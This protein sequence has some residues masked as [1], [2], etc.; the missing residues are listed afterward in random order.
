[1]Y[2]RQQLDKMSTCKVLKLAFIID[3]KTD[4][5]AVIVPV[6]NYC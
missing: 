1:M 2:T 6:R 3:E 5:Q 4:N